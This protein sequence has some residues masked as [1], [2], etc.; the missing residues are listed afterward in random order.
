MWGC[1]ETYRLDSE[2]PQINLHHSGSEIVERRN[3]TYLRNDD[4]DDSELL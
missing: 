4:F 3:N 1:L 2:P